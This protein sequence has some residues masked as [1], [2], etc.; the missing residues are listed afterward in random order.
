MKKLKYAGILFLFLSLCYIGYYILS[1]N[2][3]PNHRKFE[4]TTGI[5][6]SNFTRQI[7]VSSKKLEALLDS[8]N[9]P[10]VSIAIGVD[11]KI[12]WSEAIGYADLQNKIPATPKMALPWRRIARY[13]MSRYQPSCGTIAT[14][15]ACKFLPGNGRIVHSQRPN[16]SISRV[17]GQIITRY[18]RPMGSGCNLILRAPFPVKPRRTCR[19]TSGTLSGRAKTG[20]KR[21]TWN[22]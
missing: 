21:N 19:R 22:G 20:A 7:Q 10:S 4:K 15:P 8:L 5:S 3:L 14:A 11:N 12:V 2:K 17:T 9:V 1:W 16:S 6:N 18:C 13:C